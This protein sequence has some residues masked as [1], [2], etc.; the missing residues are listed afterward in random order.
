MGTRTIIRDGIDL[1]LEGKGRPRGCQWNESVCI[2]TPEY[3]IVERR[4]SGP[5]TQ[6]YCGRHYALAL[7]H[8][9]EV[10]LPECSSPAESHAAEFGPL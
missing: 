4:D 8:L 1:D 2:E 5:D 7:A 3:K 10:H 9:T 6:V